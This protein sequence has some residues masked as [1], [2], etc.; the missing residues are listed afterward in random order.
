MS[1]DQQLVKHTNYA[2]IADCVEQS[3]QSYR[4]N[5]KPKNLLIIGVSGVGKSTLLKAYRS[6]YPR[7][8][9][10]VKTVIPILYICLPSKPTESAMY[11][12]ILCA[13]GDP[14][15]FRGK[16]PEL[17]HRVIHLIKNCNVEL[18]IVDEIQ[19][20]LDR[21][22]LKTHMSNA[23]ALK[24]LIDAIEIPVIFSG[25]PRSKELFRINTQLRG[26]FKTAKA[27]MPFSI[28]I[29]ESRMSFQKLV[30]AL[31]K[32]SIFKNNDFFDE[33]HHLKRLFYAT[34]GILR[35]TVDLFCETE[36]L[37][38]KENE[39]TLTFRFL[40]SAFQNWILNES[41]FKKSQ[42]PNPFSKDFEERRLTQ[43]GEIYEPSDLDGDNHG[44]REIGK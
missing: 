4:S 11:S 15:P 3:H 23:D 31:L 26:R 19:H 12:E 33:A 29:E 24:S 36:I 41:R 32:N 37:A 2:I 1:I 35:N 20:F 22:K 10:E 9:T 40:Q 42:H 27:L 34:D 25:A 7:Y 16:V 5:G 30:K 39:N 21:G 17:R 14:F 8:D 13:L 44:W 38:E 18:L 43:P 6:R 28:F